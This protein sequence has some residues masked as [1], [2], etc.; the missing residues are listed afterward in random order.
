MLQEILFHLFLALA[1]ALLARFAPA[2]PRHVDSHLDDE[3]LHR[4]N[5]KGTVWVLVA[6]FTWLPLC[7][8]ALGLALHALAQAYSSYFSPTPYSIVAEL[9]NW[10]CVALVFAFATVK[11]PMETVVRRMT[12]QDTLDA[13]NIMAARQYNYD[14]ERGWTGVRN[15]FLVLGFVAFVLVSD[16][17][18]FVYKDRVV[19]N[20][21]IT[22]FQERSY[23]LTDVSHLEHAAKLQHKNGSSSDFPVY[24]LS[25]RD[26]TEWKSNFNDYGQT[27]K[28]MQYLSVIAGVQVDSVLLWQ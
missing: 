11:V 20:D 1:I 10:C 8:F 7:T 5:K 24:I 22:P 12:N 4:L 23:A 15:I 17:G 18:I 19:F 3:T 13:I 2:S 27:D 6:M 21:L 14:S 16:Y 26:G 9:P 28:A 25:M